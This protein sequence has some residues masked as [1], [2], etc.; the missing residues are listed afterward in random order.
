MKNVEEIAKAHYGDENSFEDEFD[1]LY[2]QKKINLFFLDDFIRTT[3]KEGLQDLM[4]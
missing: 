1:Y 3:Q 4:F 2:H